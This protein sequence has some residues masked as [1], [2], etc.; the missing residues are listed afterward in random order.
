MTFKQGQVIARAGSAVR[1]VHLIEDGAVGRIVIVGK[2]TVLDAV[3][4]PGWLLGAVPAMTSGRYEAMVTA[5]TTC[6]LRS[7]PIG[8]FAGPPRH[9]RSAGG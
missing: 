2:R 9:W 5:L 6:V 1:V 7:I 3:R 4:G 8:H